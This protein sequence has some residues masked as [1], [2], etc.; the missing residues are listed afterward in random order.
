MILNEEIYGNIGTVYHR[1]RSD[2]KSFTGYLEKGEWQSGSNAGNM[3][4]LGLYTVFSLES[5]QSFYGSYLYK[6]HVK[7]IKNFYIFLPKIYNKVWGTNKSYDEMIA[8]QNKRF[9]LNVKAYTDFIH[10]G[11]KLHSKCAGIIFH[12]NHDG[13]VCIIWEPR[14]VIPMKYSDDGGDTWKKLTMSKDYKSNAFKHGGDI[15]DYL[16]QDQKLFEEKFFDKNSKLIKVYKSDY[17]P[18]THPDHDEVLFLRKMK[19]LTNIKDIHKAFGSY[20]NTGSYYFDNKYFDSKSIAVFD[21]NQNLKDII[22]FDGINFRAVKNS[23]YTVFVDAVFGDKYLVKKEKKIFDRISRKSFR[24]FENGSAEVYANSRHDFIKNIK[25]P[26]SLK[27][28]IKIDNITGRKNVY[29]NSSKSFGT[30]YFTFDFFDENGKKAKKDLKNKLI[31]DLKNK[32]HL[33][34][35]E[36]WIK[37]GNKQFFSDLGGENSIESMDD[38]S[39]HI[40]S[41]QTEKLKKFIKNEFEKSNFFLK[42][43]QAISKRVLKINDKK[44]NSGSTLDTRTTRKKVKNVDYKANSMSE[45]NMSNTELNKMKAKLEREKFERE[46]QKKYVGKHQYDML[47][48]VQTY[49]PY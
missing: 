22:Y 4:G 14:N 36:D 20:Y 2:P 16:R 8:E 15:V 37:E 10:S 9:G 34:N 3:Y 12:G 17:L 11:S 38:I 44:I 24:P 30:L 27:N 45:L 5:N 49:F 43:E 41:K 35:I 48:S 31:E 1:S 18:D 26:D 28:F 42:V 33:N 46:A 39:F 29:D 6:L 25:V 32:L 40:N 47:K 7:G 13:D 21:S 23:D 19:K